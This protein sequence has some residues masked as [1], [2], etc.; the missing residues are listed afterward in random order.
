MFILPFLHKKIADTPI[1]VVQFFLAKGGT[2]LLSIPSDSLNFCKEN[3]IPILNISS[4]KDIEYIQVDASKLQKDVFYSFNEKDT[5]DLEVWR[6]FIWVGNVGADPWSV[7][8]SLEKIVLSGVKV[9]SL[10]ETV[11]RNVT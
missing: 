2:S 6:T 4:S 1:Y 5:Q 3:D 11:L 7:N 9:T 10:M 8:T